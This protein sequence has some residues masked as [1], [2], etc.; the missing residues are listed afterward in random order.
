MDIGAVVLDQCYLLPTGKL[1]SHVEIIH[2][3]FINS[4]I[5]L[6]FLGYSMTLLQVQILHTAEMYSS[7]VTAQ[8]Y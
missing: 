4:I 2:V 3:P 1:F 6:K 7:L 5:S 8:V